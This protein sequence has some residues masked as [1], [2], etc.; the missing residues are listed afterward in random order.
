MTSNGESN[1]SHY[2]FVIAPALFMLM[3]V[4]S[5][6]QFVACIYYQNL[7]GM[8]LQPTIGYLLI[9]LSPLLMLLF[10]SINVYVMM[11]IAG[12]GIV[13]HRLYGSLDAETSLYMIFHAFVIIAYSLYFPTF[14]MIYSSL[15]GKLN[16]GRL[17][18]AIVIAPVLMLLFDILLTTLGHTLDLTVVGIVSPAGTSVLHPLLVAL[19]LCA[20]ALVALAQNYAIIAKDIPAVRSVQRTGIA[21]STVFPG[22]C[23]GLV[24]TNLLLFMG[25]PGVVIRWTVGS[26]T[27]A[28]LCA[29]ATLFLLLALLQWRRCRDALFLPAVQVF[30]NAVQIAVVVDVLF[31]DSGATQYFLGV[32]LASLLLDMFIFCH[33]VACRNYSIQYFITFITIGVATFMAVFFATSF[34][35]VWAHVPAGSYFKGALPAIL[36]GITGAYAIAAVCYNK[37]VQPSL[38]EGPPMPSP[39]AAGAA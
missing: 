2:S 34:S 11:V 9:F 12:V 25:S 7:T 33:A 13:V 5:T 16:R 19:P 28:V 20:L 10:R 26:S 38:G 29:S 27:T 8:G 17:A 30:L 3:F 24:L 21:V 32:A 23:F 39:E 6:R 31:L 18:P 37:R 35:L 22:I 14:L 15:N 4:E 36:L 1:V